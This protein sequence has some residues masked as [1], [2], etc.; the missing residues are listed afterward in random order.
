ME[1]KLFTLVEDA[2]RR[3]QRLVAP[4]VGFP[5]L[6]LYPS[7]IKIAQQNSEEHIRV[8]QAIERELHPDVLFPLMDLSV[9]AN[10]LGQYTVFP[11]DDSATVEQEFY[12][13][14]E[15]LKYLRSV[16]LLADGRVQVYV[17]TVE[18]MK[19]LISSSVLIGCYVTGPYTLA[20]LLL[21]ASEAATYCVLKSA[22][23]HAYCTLAAEKIAEYAK[24][25]VAAGAQ[26]VCVLEPSGVMLG[27]QQFREFS[28]SYVQKIHEEVGWNIPFVYHVCGNSMHIID[29]MCKAGVQALSI[30]SPEAGVDIQKVAEHA[31]KDI[32]LI[33]NVCPTGTILNA[34]PEKVRR[35]TEELLQRM[36][37]FPNFLLSTGCDLPKNVPIENIK[38][39]IE[40]GRSYRLL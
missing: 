36:K 4:L 28:A 20:G 11:I 18:R 16:S 19:Q 35:E 40:T 6:Q 32:I 13:S 29:E 26:F 23:L 10:A 12:Y 34:S 2:Y 21:G 7:T 17:Q 5:G 25:L 22:F 31:P 30:D 1:N 37:P 8:L 9:E 33:G 38:A 3:K 27:P 14:E 15:H 24:A 39:F